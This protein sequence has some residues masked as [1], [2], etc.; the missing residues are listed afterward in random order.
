MHAKGP[1]W[2]NNH[3]HKLIPLPLFHMIQA[4]GGHCVVSAR[5]VPISLYLDTLFQNMQ[6][7]DG[8]CFVVAPFGCADRIAVLFCGRMTVWS[9]ADIDLHFSKMILFC[10]IQCMY[11]PLLDMLILIMVS[12]CGTEH[13]LL[14]ILLYLQSSF[15]WF[16]VASHIPIYWW[17]DSTF[18]DSDARAQEINSTAGKIEHVS[19]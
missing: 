18:G 6:L 1:E 19:F 7:R 9:W 12:V 11:M 3:G 5:C 4:R 8:L 16:F 10:A 13:A 17:F 15:F 2:C 14:S